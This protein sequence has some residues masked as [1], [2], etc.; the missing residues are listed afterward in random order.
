M[1]WKENARKKKGNL[2]NE[3][4]KRN[5]TLI[6]ISSKW[7]NQRIIENVPLNS[8]VNLKLNYD[9]LAQ[10]RAEA[11]KFHSA[12][13]YI[14]DQLRLSRSKNEDFEWMKNILA[15]GTV[16]D[17][18]AVYTILIQESAVHNLRLLESLIRFVNPKGK[19]ECM[20]AIDTIRDL[21]V[22]NL[23]I[24][25]QKLCSFEELVNKVDSNFLL[26]SD[27]L[28][29]SRK[30]FLIMTHVED[31]I[32]SFYKRFLEQL[33]VCSHDTLDSLKIKSIN[34]MF[35]LFVN[36]P[37]QEKFLLESLI[38]KLGDPAPKVASSTS[39][40]LL[41]IL[42]H[43]PPM[44]ILIV[45]EVER[46]IFRPKITNRTQYYCLCFLS[47]IIYRANVDQELANYVI[48]IYFAIFT[49][50]A[51]L[52]EINNKTMSVLLTGVSRAF[53]YS[54]LENEVIEKYLNTFYRLIHYVNLNTAIQTLSLIFD[55]VAFRESGS[56]TDRFYSCLYRFL[57]QPSLDQSN[58][59]NILLNIV[60]R[61]MV[62]DPVIKRVRAFAK[63]LL[64]VILEK[65]DLYI[66][67]SL[68]LFSRYLYYHQP[69]LLL[70]F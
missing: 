25:K 5:Q 8:N 3:F 53:P 28:E 24:P 34:T 45:K 51:K 61:S 60:F 43:H 15:N 6:S 49:K 13:Y 54:K 23:L 7:Y 52:G 18:L 47:E 2:N 14:Y 17:K 65:V 31:K 59:L 27:S 66:L 69:R 50:C 39:K 9:Q 16:N 62:K 19:R 64:Q 46:L 22:G 26:N 20:M 30:K 33:V 38:N 10:L 11:I 32:R 40:L 44:K 12:D 41:K 68:Q 42:Q 36:H 58:K 57:L 56:L 55:M 21:F 67:I 37:E 4:K 35:D 48:N 29:D 1:E 63:R 70:L